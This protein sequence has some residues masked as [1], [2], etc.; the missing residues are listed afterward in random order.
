MSRDAADAATA[1]IFHSQRLRAVGVVARCDN[2]RRSDLFRGR[3]FLVTMRRKTHETRGENV[4]ICARP[5]TITQL[6]FKRYSKLYINYS[7]NFHHF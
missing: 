7:L 6:D 5:V 1:S 4:E 2:G 3:S